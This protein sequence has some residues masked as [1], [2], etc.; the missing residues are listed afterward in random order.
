M[1]GEVTHYLPP[2]A[3]HGHQK[4]LV[5]NSSISTADI[6]EPLMI[7]KE[8]S[9]GETRLRAANACTFSS[10]IGNGPGPA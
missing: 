5:T 3:W 2:I 10:R 1:P 4:S 6:P 9:Y 7:E 8:L